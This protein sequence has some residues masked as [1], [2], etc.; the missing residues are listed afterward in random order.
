MKILFRPIVLLLLALNFGC[1]GSSS[2]ATGGMPTPVSNS[3]YPDYNTQALTADATGMADTAV[4][5]AQK[6]RIGLNIGN[7]MESTG[8][9]GETAWGNPTITREFVQFAKASGFN[10][11]RLPV[12]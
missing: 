4:P 1:G 3:P 8:G 2:A 10:A 5:T 9:K 11:I 12:S 7:T 6:M